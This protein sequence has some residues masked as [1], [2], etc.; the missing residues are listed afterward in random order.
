MVK[1]FFVVGNRGR[2]VDVFP[3]PEMA[4]RQGFKDE[5]STPIFEFV[6]VNMSGLRG[7]SETI[8]MKPSK[9]EEDK[10][11]KSLAKRFYSKRDDYG[12]YGDVIQISRHCISTKYI[13][14]RIRSYMYTVDS[15]MWRA[16]IKP[17]LAADLALFIRDL[18]EEIFLIV[19]RRKGDP[20][21]GTIAASGGFINIRGYEMET[22]AQ[23]ALRETYEEICAKMVASAS[24][25]DRIRDPKADNV[26]ISVDIG[27]EKNI[28]AVLKN[29][30]AY[31][32]EKREEIP[33]SKN[34]KLPLK[35]VYWTFVYATLVEVE[36]KLNAKTAAALFTPKDD[37][38]E[39]MAIPFKK[40]HKTKFGFAHHQTFIGDAAKYIR[41]NFM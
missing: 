4:S 17:G 38:E 39:V 20:G 15:M 40:I 6:P 8:H 33:E 37:A 1:Y 12:R 22:G 7:L 13:S 29:L 31:V 19:I 24:F 18:N 34:N 2:I 28:P 30:G 26:P 36:A 5:E 32:T 3:D 35:R 23:C 41:R 10:I 25:A 21:A 11:V 16:F 27:K 9:K 14:T